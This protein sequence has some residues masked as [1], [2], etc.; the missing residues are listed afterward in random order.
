MSVSTREELK[1]YCLRRLGYPV[2]EINVDDEQLEDRMDDA[3][4]FFYEYHFNGVESIYLKQLLTKT[5][6]DNR[7]IN[8][9]ESILSIID[10]YPVTSSTIGMFDVRYQFMMNE[11]WDFASMDLVYYD[12]V[13]K[14][15]STLDLFLGQ[16]K[17][18][19]FNR[20]SGK[21][22]FDTDWSRL[23]PKEGTEISDLE[24]I[25]S[26]ENYEVGDVITTDGD[27][28]GF[29]AV[30]ESVSSS[31]SVV[32]ISIENEGKGF[33]YDNTNI[34][35]I[36]TA[37]GT[38]LELKETIG[39]S[40]LIIKAYRVLNPND[41]PRLYNDRFLKLYTTQLFKQQWGANLIKF[42]GISLPGN[43]QL[44]GQKIY[45]NATEELKTLKEEML[46][47]YSDPIDFFIG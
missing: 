5:D 42:S 28:S 4:Q 39:K 38:G 10:V 18:S 27:E 13:Q 33:S 45:D 17:I 20:V 37:S 43:V 6:Y 7:Y 21:L 2:I 22:Y 47:D 23:F 30:I 9:P 16:Q 19:R 31:G 36:D 25:S 40:Y 34:F 24:I 41:T 3:M 11:V 12:T 29:T 44:D 35:S 8:V 26:G 15:L 46:K 1:E 32:S 14:H